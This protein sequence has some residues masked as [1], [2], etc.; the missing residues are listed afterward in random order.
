MINI[1]GQTFPYDDPTL[2]FLGIC[3]AKWEVEFPGF[4]AATSLFS[5]KLNLKCHQVNV[6]D[7]VGWWSEQGGWS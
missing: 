3:F 6:M 7:S 4:E 2:F 1:F 5:G